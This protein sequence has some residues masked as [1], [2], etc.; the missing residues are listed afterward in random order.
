VNQNPEDDGQGGEHRNH[1]H[2]VLLDRTPGVRE[3]ARKVS[4]HNQ[5]TYPLRWTRVGAGI[6][7]KRVYSQYVTAT[8]GEEQLTG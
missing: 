1:L 3:L 5:H 2:P 6:Q 4:L 7:R 8:R